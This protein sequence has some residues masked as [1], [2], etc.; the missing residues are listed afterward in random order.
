[1]GTLARNHGK[2]EPRRTSSGGA[3]QASVMGPVTKHSFEQGM[4]ALKTRQS[5]ICAILLLLFS[6]PALAQQ[7]LL[8]IDDIFDPVKRVNFSGSVPNI[9]WLKDGVHY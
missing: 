9:R 3:A 6:L 2:A 8:T 1:M 5:L 4:T 7:K